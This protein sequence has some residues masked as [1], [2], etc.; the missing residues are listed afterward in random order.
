MTKTMTMMKMMKM[1]VSLFAF[2]I[3]KKNQKKNK[4]LSLKLSHH[5]C[6]KCK[7]AVGES[8]ETNDTRRPF[9]Y[10]QLQMRMCIALASTMLR[11]IRVAYD[12]D[13]AGIGSGL[14]LTLDARKQGSISK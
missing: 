9:S 14:P 3:L 10:I 5:S 12:P 13:A 7:Y 4:Y 1:P 2:A 11:R 6:K 8:S